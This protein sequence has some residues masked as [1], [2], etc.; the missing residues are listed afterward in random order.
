MKEYIGNVCL[1]LN[2]YE[3]V[4]KYSDGPIEDELL[5]IVQ[6][7]DK[8]EYMK[9]VEERQS[10]PLLYHLSEQRW[11]IIEGIPMGESDHVLEIGAG[12]GA[13]TGALARK[14]GRVTCIELSKKRSM[15]NAYRNRGKDNIEIKVGNFETVHKNLHKKYDIITLIG[16]FEYAQSYIDS[17]NPFV[18]FLKMIEGHLAEHGRIVIAIE[19][20]YGLKYWAGCREDHVNTFFSGLEGYP[21]TDRARTFGKDRLEELLKTAGL[22]DVKFFYPY[23]DYKFVMRIYSDEYLP[24]KGELINNMRNYDND[25]MY[26]FNEEMVYDSLIEDKMFPFFSNS[27]LVVARR[28]G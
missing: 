17:E 14:A 5:E 28:E 23:P 13:I 22:G 3:G 8:A 9:I 24:Q 7:V 1:D 4:D 11:N 25:R 18:D 12:C 6:T 26:L 19:N 21:G 27:Y 10:W 2:D 20:K 15:I 16:V